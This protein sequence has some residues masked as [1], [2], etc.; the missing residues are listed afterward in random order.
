MK[1][2]YH[3]TYSQPQSKLPQTCNRVT[4][5]NIA[6][7]AIFFRSIVLLPIGYELLVEN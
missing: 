3:L 6:L 5:K 2:L 1:T 7:I 4:L